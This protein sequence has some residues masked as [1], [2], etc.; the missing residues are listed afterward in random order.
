[1]IGTKM[2]EQTRNALERIQFTRRHIGRFGLTGFA[3]PCRPNKRG[4]ILVD[5]TGTKITCI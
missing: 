3:D 5:H 1:M 4:V 2:F